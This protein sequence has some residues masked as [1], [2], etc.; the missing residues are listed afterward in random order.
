MPG[1]FVC[2]RRAVCPTP[3]CV[4]N[5][6]ADHP[7]GAR[8]PVHPYM[9]GEYLRYSSAQVSKIGSSPRAWGIRHRLVA[10]FRTFWFIPTCVGNTCRKSKTECR[11]SVHPHVRGE[12]ALAQGRRA[13]LAGSSPRAWGIPYSPQGFHFESRFIPTCVGNTSS[14]ST[15]RLGMTVHPHVRGEY[16]QLGPHFFGLHGSSPR[17]WGIPRPL[18]CLLVVIRFIPTCVGNTGRAALSGLPR[19]VH[20]HVRGEYA[21]V[22]SAALKPSGSSP[23]AWGIRE[24]RRS[25]HPG[26]RFIPT[27]VGNTLR[28]WPC[29]GWETV[30]PHVRGEYDEPSA[31]FGRMAG[32]SPRAWGIPRMQARG[33]RT[34][35]FIPTCVGNTIPDVFS[36][37]RFTVHPHVRGEYGMESGGQLNPAGSSP[38]AWGI[39]RPAS[40]TSAPP[41]FIPT[42][43][44]NTLPENMKSS[45]RLSSLQKSTDQVQ[46][47]PAR[48]EPGKSR[49]SPPVPCGFSRSP[50]RKILIRC[51][52]SRPSP[53]S[54]PV[55]HH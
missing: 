8:R 34:L 47:D 1:F 25:R 51:S 36:S 48:I 42:C 26:Q 37:S 53:H 24:R 32:S 13:A 33:I 40:T 27:C 15:S 45:Q 23:R 11:T 19:S 55:S 28:E 7:H 41:R 22:I 35:R 52:Y 31:Y 2:L 30:H 10:H 9:R 44:G 38:R 4:G 49:P 3:T 5:T 16:A 46:P 39:H 6:S 20:P 50:Q 17:A 18:R 29:S 14:N 21:P 43:V 54:L 12:Y